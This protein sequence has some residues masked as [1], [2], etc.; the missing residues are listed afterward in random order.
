M[1]DSKT[2]AFILKNFG[3]A[4]H[5]RKGL[6]EV[7]TDSARDACLLAKQLSP[8][9]N[10]SE[11]SAHGVMNII[12]NSVRNFDTESAGEYEKLLQAISAAHKIWSKKDLPRPGA[13]NS[14]NSLLRTSEP[15]ES[16][17]NMFLECHRLANRFSSKSKD[18]NLHNCFV[19]NSL[20]GTR[21]RNDFIN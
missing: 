14:L 13:M 2:K 6:V 20:S 5:V 18:P 7:C 21:F 3:L 15:S 11:C 8:K 17:K 16:D 10:T 9:G 19:V 12:I 4:D 1:L